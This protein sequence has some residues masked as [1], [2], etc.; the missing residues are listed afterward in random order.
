VHE[1]E[2]KSGETTDVMVKLVNGESH[3]MFILSAEPKE[4]SIV[5]ILGPVRMEDL[6]KLKHIGGLGALGDIAKDTTVTK[7]T[8]AKDKEK[9]KEKTKVKTGDNE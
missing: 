2:R 8:T 6:G 3:G 5:L 9:T 7:D 1:R 4:L